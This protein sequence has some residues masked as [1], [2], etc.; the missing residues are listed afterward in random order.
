MNEV[1]F[2]IHSKNN[3]FRSMTIKKGQQNCQPLLSG[4]PDSRKLQPEPKLLSI[5]SSISRYNSGIL[6][7]TAPLD[8]RVVNSHVIVN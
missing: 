6:F 4:S 7:F 5:I 8:N 2:L 1:I 3:W